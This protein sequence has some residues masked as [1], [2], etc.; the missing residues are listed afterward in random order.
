MG[1]E[2][3][4][5]TALTGSA[6]PVAVSVVPPVPVPGAERPQAAQLDATAS[7]P[8]G[9]GATSGRL[10]RHRLRTSRRS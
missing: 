5:G 9:A 7:G 6:C 2:A 10:G 4:D 1:V 8:E 3:P